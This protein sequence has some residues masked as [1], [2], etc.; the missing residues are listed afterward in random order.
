MPRQHGGHRVGAGGGE[1][2]M[3]RPHDRL[4]GLEISHLPPR[5]SAG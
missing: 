4:L 1:I 2:G 5:L 3:K